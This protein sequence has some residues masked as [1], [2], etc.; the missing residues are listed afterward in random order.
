MLPRLTSGTR[1]CRVEPP[2]PRSGAKTSVCGLRALQAGRVVEEDA[3]IT[4]G[5]L[6]AI[7][8]TMDPTAGV[9]VALFR[10]DATTALFDISHV[11]DQNGNAQLNVEEVPNPH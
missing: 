7:L 4:I 2:A 5:E 3:G 6:L 10:A 8:Q 11:T 1:D 9:L